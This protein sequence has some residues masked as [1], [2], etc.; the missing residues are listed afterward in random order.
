VLIEAHGDRLVVACG[1][2]TALG[3][4]EIQPEGRRPMSARDFLAGRRLSPGDRFE[5]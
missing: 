4:L 2:G 5:T 3:I 1:D